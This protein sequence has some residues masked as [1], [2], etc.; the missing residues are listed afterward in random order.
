MR[1]E[2]TIEEKAAHFASI[3]MMDRAN[4]YATIVL[5]NEIKELRKTINERLQA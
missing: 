3:G 5:I 2:Q 1:I 4:Y